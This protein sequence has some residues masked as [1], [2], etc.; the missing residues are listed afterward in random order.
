MKTEREKNNKEKAKYCIGCAWLHIGEKVD[1][2]H[3][4]YNYADESHKR[5]NG[6]FDYASYDGGKTYKLTS[7]FSQCRWF[8][9]EKKNPNPSKE[10]IYYKAPK[11]KRCPKIP[12]IK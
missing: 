8:W 4:D 6:L 5:V 9:D 12:E 7:H 3:C 2:N 10:G 1:H 11:S